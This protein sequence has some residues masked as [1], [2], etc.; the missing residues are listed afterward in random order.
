MWF[1]PARPSDRSIAPRIRRFTSTSASSRRCKTAIMRRVISPKL[2]VIAHE[3]GHHVQNL[4]GTIEKVRTRQR[5]LSDLEGKELSVRLELQADFLAGAW[6]HHAEKA[7]HILEPGDL[8]KSSRPCRHSAM[9]ATNPNKKV[10]EVTGWFMRCWDGRHGTAE[11]R[12]RWF[13]SRIQDRRS[14]PGRH[15]RDR[16]VI[17]GSERSAGR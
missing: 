3:V 17:G 1:R 13:K 16:Q 2:N 10:A 4:L 12:A 5:G 14:E 8:E 11:Q 6:A 7:R 15:A 9:I